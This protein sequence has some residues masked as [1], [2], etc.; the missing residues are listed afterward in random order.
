LEAGTVAGFA[1]T[2]LPATITLIKTFIQRQDLVPTRS[3]LVG[4]SLLIVAMCA[5]ATALQTP[6]ASHPK[7]VPT[8]VLSE[9]DSGT[10]IDLT[11]NALLIVKLNSNPSTGYSWTVT[12]DPS[13]LKLQKTSFRKNTNKSGIMGASGTATFQLSANSSG[14]ATLTLVYRRS[15][16][17]NM[18]PM[19]TFTVRVNV[20]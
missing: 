14:I 8:V 13:P 9:R 18:P 15:W 12:G 1:L 10:D 17:Y 7:A 11:S 16:E 19:K 6:D 20:R 5:S 3:S 2:I 4:F